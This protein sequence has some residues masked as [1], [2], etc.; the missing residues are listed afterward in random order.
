MQMKIYNVYNFLFFSQG[1]FAANV[2]PKS[3]CGR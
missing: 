2:A 3:T 1:E